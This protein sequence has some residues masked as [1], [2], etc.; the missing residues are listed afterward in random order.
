ML[1]GFMEQHN[2]YV[3]IT[4]VSSPVTTSAIS[5]RY[6][7]L[8]EKEG[9]FSLTTGMQCLIAGFLWTGCEFYCKLFTHNQVL[10]DFCKFC[11]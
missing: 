8:L 10:H 11:I 1:T 3:D 7:N 9:T 6:N 4:T 5:A 2:V